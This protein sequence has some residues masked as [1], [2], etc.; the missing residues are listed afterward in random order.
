LRAV[1]HTIAL[2]SLAPAPGAREREW[3]AAGCDTLVENVFSM[4]GVR[5]KLKELG[6]AGRA[7]LFG[8]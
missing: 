2:G 3:S 4:A 6:P 7:Q 5:V 8:L 1:F